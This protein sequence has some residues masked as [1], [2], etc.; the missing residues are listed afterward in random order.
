MGARQITQQNQQQQVRQRTK[1]QKPRQRPAKLNSYVTERNTRATTAAQRNPYVATLMDPEGHQ[2]V[3]FPDGFNQATAMIP[4]MV[5]TNV[6]YFPLSYSREVPGSWNLFIKPDPVHPV[7]TFGPNVSAAGNYM[8]GFVDEQASYGL[9]PL[10]PTTP[11]FSRQAGNMILDSG[12]KTNV[13]YPA[14]ISTLDWVQEP[15][16]GLATDGT[17]FYGHPFNGFSTAV[18]FQMQVRTILNGLSV[19]A[20]DSLL[21]ELVDSRGTP[22]VSSNVVALVGQQ[23]FD[24]G[25]MTLDS[26]AGTSSNA[27]IGRECGRPGVGLRVTWTAASGQ[28]AEVTSI[29]VRVYGTAA[30]SR[31]CQYPIDLPEKDRS[32][33]LESVDKLRSVSCSA[34]CSYVGD[35]FQNGGQI[36]STSYQG[37]QH[38]H[39]L[40]L[41]DYQGIAESNTRPHVG[42]LK[43]GSYCIWKPRDIQDMAM[44]DTVSTLGWDFP[45]IA[46]AG[47]VTEADAAT[48]LSLRVWMNMEVIST[49]RFL[50]LGYAQDKP[51]LIREAFHILREFPLAG[52]ND[53]HMATIRSFLNTVWK[54]AKDTV[55]WIADNK[56]WLV[57]AATLAGSLLL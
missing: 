49:A 1:Q 56:G 36:A 23:N 50:S 8:G 45:Y 4:A 20:G 24:S 35:T 14:K 54:G 41:W 42:K 6:P 57:P 32:V 18:S 9:F 33:F 39:D 31:V 53:T 13:K 3:R 26:F 17:T 29:Q 5:Q 34:L 46:M 38:P 2:G 51:G 12:I 15:Y 19:A 43:E 37:G 30:T 55:T 25:N 48:R 16:Q 52:K 22:V 7:W 11:R 47:I 21:Y 27:A 28:S 44:R 40:G 10:D